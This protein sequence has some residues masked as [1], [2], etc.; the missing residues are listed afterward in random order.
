MTETKKQKRKAETIEDLDASIQSME[1]ELAEGYGTPLS[2]EE[3]TTTTAAELAAKEQRR[4][5]L[6]RL[7]AAAKAKRL[8]LEIAGLEAKARALG[9]EREENY[10]R[11]EKATDKARRAEEE[12]E[13]ARGAWATALGTSQDLERRIRQRKRELRELREGS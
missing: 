7:I 6:P 1:A 9:A 2:W 12:R 4:S 13:A 3:V 5:I 10:H 8:E 11:L